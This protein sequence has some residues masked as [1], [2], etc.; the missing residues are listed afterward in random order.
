MAYDNACKYLSE[1][2]PS[3][4]AGWILGQVPPSV[5]VL[6]T[7]LSIE[8]IR[9]DYLT[10]LRTRE[11]ILHLEFEVDVDE[12]PPLPLRMLDYWMRLHRRYRVPV[13]Q[14]L[15]LLKETPAAKRLKD[16]FRVENT[17]HRYQIIRMWEQD[18]EPLLQNPALLPLASLCRTDAP[19]RL[20]SQVAQELAKIKTP[21]QRGQIT[22]CSTILAGLRFDKNSIRQLFREDIMRESVIYQDILEQGVQQGLQ[23]G[24]QQAL[25]TSI[26]DA[27]DARFGSVP[28]EVAPKL[29]G[30]TPEQLQ[31]LLRQAVLCGTLDA[32][33]RQLG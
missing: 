19:E 27:L 28:A 9:A 8:P 18:P 13:T 6:K 1:T 11:R 10:F 24:Q 31:G 7:E 21:A 4:F 14:A 22:A 29:E 12:E 20:L 15:I 33:I 26:L 3:Q 32:F 17:R 25:K 23:Q 5:E 16:T 2:Y 30:L